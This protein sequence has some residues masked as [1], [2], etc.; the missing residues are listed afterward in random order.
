M[1]YRSRAYTLEATAAAPQR[2][3]THGTH[4]S[5][6]AG[7]CIRVIFHKSSDDK[8]SMM[9]SGGD[10][11]RVTIQCEAA[12][13]SELEEHDRVMM[14]EVTKVPPATK[15]RITISLKEMLSE[16]CSLRSYLDAGRRLRSPPHWGP[17]TI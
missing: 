3:D 4:E 13:R 5:M 17:K 14:F 2:E 10:E 15:K 6:S 8:I 12:L 11:R 1:K 16:E 7:S 9:I